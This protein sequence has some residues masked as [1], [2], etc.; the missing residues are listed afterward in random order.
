MQVG[1]ALGGSELN[2]SEESYSSVTAADGTRAGSLGL[3]GLA[4]PPLVLLQGS[5]S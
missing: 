5:S 1:Y 2:H 3:L 4:A